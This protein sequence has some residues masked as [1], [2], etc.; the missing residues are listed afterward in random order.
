MNFFEEKTDIYYEQCSFWALI[1]LFTLVQSTFAPSTS[2]SLIVNGHCFYHLMW[3][4]T[5]CVYFIV[6]CIHH[7]HYFEAYYHLYNIN[8][9][10]M[11]NY[12]ASLS[13]WVAEKNHDF[14][15]TKKDS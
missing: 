12:T 11:N 14:N 4:I 5:S 1:T 2:G 3:Y 8:N 10:D 6:A 9:I 13:R 15:R 7:W